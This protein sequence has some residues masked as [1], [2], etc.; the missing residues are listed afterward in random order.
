MDVSLD[1]LLDGPVFLRDLHHAPIVLDRGEGAYLYDEAGN[2]YLDAAAGAAVASIG[3]GRAEVAEA[4]ARQARRLA[5]AHPSK[6]ITRPTLE[7]AQKMVD[8]APAGFN[9]VFFTSGGSESVEAAIKLARQA[10]VARGL[11]GKHK[12]VSRRTSYH[13]A[14]LGALAVTDQEERTAPFAPLL[15]VEPKI[16]PCYPYRCRDCAATRSCTTACAD[17]LER[18]VEEEGAA[19]LAAFIAEPIVGSSAPGSHGPPAYWRRIRDICD[20][21]DVIFVADE[22][23]SG[24]GRSGTWWAMQGTG[25]TPDLIATAKGIGAGYASLGALLVHD[26]VFEA[27]R[28]SKRDFA[29]G[30]TYSGNPL[31]AAV[32][33][34][35]IDV[36]E[37]EGLLDTVTAMGELLLKRL[38]ETLGDHPHVGDV[39]GRGLL[40]GVEFVADRDTRAPFDPNLQV[41]TRVSRACL[42][43]GL[44]VYGGGGS[45]GRMGG[46]HVLI[47][48]PFIVT[49]EQVTF[50]VETLCEALDAVVADL[51]GTA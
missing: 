36:I 12:I 30:H 35:V 6:F 9:R 23:M 43:R 20:A 10:H 34:V 18:V 48:P 17:D 24:N 19:A 51:P 5:F 32:G 29:H 13:G 16:A 2:R 45:A 26:D 11:D 46:D 22:V 15:R 38:A 39:R 37:R 25:V 1:P 50:L 47:A 21:H 4:L 14:T 49:S 8:R 41:R 42:E 40:A 3:H 31:A 28:A 44:Y 7:L 33:S 27:L